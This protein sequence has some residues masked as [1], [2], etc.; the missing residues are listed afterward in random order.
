MSIF[1]KENKEKHPF[2]RLKVG[3]S[4]EIPDG[5]SVQSMRC[6]AY[7]RGETLGMKFKVSKKTKTVERVA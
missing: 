2:S 3:E 5:L 4:F 1:E 6:L 7:Q